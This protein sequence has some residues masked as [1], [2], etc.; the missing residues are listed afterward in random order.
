MSAPYVKNNNRR[1]VLDVIRQS[2]D[3]TVGSISQKTQLSKPTIKT[4]I[5]F[6]LSNGLVT[7]AGKGSST[8]EGGKRP[9]LFRFNKEYGFVISL[10][11]GPDFIFSALSNMNS[12]IL[13]SR[14]IPIGRLDSALM[15]E[16][17]VDAARDYM[18]N[19]WTRGKHLISIEIGLPGIVDSE[20]GVS[21]FSPHYPD[22]G[23]DLPF[24]SIFRE[25]LGTNCPIHIDCVNRYQAFAE[26]MEG[27]GRGT[28]NLIIVDAMEVGLGAGVIVDGRLKHGIN[29]LSGEI[30][31]MVLQVDGPLCNCG[32]RGCFEALVRVDNVVEILKKGFAG[33]EDSIVYQQGNQLITIDN[34]FTAAAEGDL[35]AD[36]VLDHIATWFAIGLNNIIMVNDPKMIVI[37][38]VYTG[39]GIRFLNTLKNKIDNLSLPGLRRGVELEYSTLGDD[40][41]VI[42]QAYFGIWNYFQSD[43]VYKTDFSTG[44]SKKVIEKVG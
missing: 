7:A 28:R 34:L 23:R 30:G 5:D 14:Q 26:L 16:L 43:E 36:E 33:H 32:G 35:F 19:S 13:F 39:A 31:H 42:G 44:L 41:C 22:W 6:Y 8:D 3:L 15:I 27:V 17:L 2:E 10:H 40:R 12:D 38:G 18:N 4:I 24:V 29:N 21:V 37:Q 1:V 20:R 11:V 9:T 25:Q